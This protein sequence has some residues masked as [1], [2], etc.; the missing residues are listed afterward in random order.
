AT[1]MVKS[2]E[3]MSTHGIQRCRRGSDS[4][5]DQIPSCSAHLRL[6]GWLASGDLLVGLRAGSGGKRPTTYPFKIDGSLERFTKELTMMVRA[7]TMVHVSDPGPC[8]LRK[9]EAL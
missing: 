6:T 4:C 1:E 5:R 2:P 7:H 3:V 9:R 8:A